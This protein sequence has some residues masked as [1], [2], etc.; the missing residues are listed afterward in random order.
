MPKFVIVISPDKLG[1]SVGH[2]DAY[3]Y[4]KRDRELDR[5][6][7][8]IEK[9]RKRAEELNREL[10]EYG[11]R[12]EVRVNTGKLQ[13]HDLAEP[14]LEEP[15]VEDDKVMV[16]WWSTIHDDVYLHKYGIK[17]REDLEGF[18]NFLKREFPDA[19]I[20]IQDKE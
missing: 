19:E 12:V 5:L 4:V 14:F 11:I 18:V 3:I 7:N 17:H 9:L 16:A 15:K 6:L 2:Y 13:T 10:E 1:T 8:E 20:I